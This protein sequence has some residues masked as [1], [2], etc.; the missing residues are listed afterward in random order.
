MGWDPNLYVGVSAAPDLI[1]EVIREFED[2]P[3]NHAF[4][5]YEDTHT[6]WRALGANLNGVTEDSWDNFVRS[7]KVLGLWRPR[8]PPA[9]WVGLTKLKDD[10]NEKYSIAGL[11]GM[12]VVEVAARLFHYHV[13][14]LLGDLFRHELFCSQFAAEIIRAS[15]Y[16]FAGEQP[17][18]TIDPGEILSM[19]PRDGR[20]VAIEK[21]PG[22]NSG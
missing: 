19:L 15:G 9:L 14:N 13:R 2:S 21:M 20:F 4:L 5:A 7:R 8:N 16:V 1:G 11:V 12:S 6:G 10:L 17:A 18:D 3:A 22:I